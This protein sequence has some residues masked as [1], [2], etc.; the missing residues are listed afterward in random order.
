M[1]F[2]AVRGHSGNFPCDTILTANIHS[3]S[4]A[5]AT[6]CAGHGDS[7]GQEERK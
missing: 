2:S 1:G 4:F 7:P 6:G 5:L 3:S